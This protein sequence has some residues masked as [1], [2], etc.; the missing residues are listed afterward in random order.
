MWRGL[1]RD[2]A[3]EGHVRPGCSPA[4]SFAQNGK[5]DASLFTWPKPS[6]MRSYGLKKSIPFDPFLRYNAR[7]AEPHAH[8]HP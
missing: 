4:D 1:A 8:R 2:F 5:I 6:T 3:L 7:H